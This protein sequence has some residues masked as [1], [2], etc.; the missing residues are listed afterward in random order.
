[1]FAPPT[2][3]YEFEL[4][5]LRTLPLLPTLRMDAKL[6]TLRS[7]QALPT[8]RM[9]A[10]LAID[11]RLQ[12]L[13]RL[14]R[15]AAV[16]RN[17]QVARVVIATAA[18]A[19]V[20]FC[21]GIRTTNSSFDLPYGI[22]KVSRRRAGQKNLTADSAASDSR[23]GTMSRQHV[24]PELLFM[25]ER[26]VEQT[27]AHRASGIPRSN[28][29]R[30][31]LL[32]LSIGAVEDLRHCGPYERSDEAFCEVFQVCLP[33][34]GL[35]VWHVGAD[36]V[37][38]DANQAVF[39]RAGEP[40]RM[41]APIGDGYAELI[42]TADACVLADIA[43]VAETLISEH[44][45]FRR[46]SW[47]VGPALQA[48]RTRFLHWAT[49]APDIDDLQADE[50]V[51]AVLR[52]AFQ[53]DGRRR[54]ACGKRT[55]RLIRRAKEFLQA[56]LA[57]RVQLGDVSRAVAASPAYLTDVFR[58]V[59]GLSLHQYLTQLRLGRALVELPYTNDLTALALETGFSS[60]SHFSAVF[61]RAFG[62]TP[63]RFRQTSRRALTWKTR[64]PLGRTA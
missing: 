43:G 1:V 59:E 60:H 47:L 3:R 39:V 14:D 4:P 13:R 28:G 23:L 2:L 10:K 57:E 12:A 9:L 5:T 25:E 56:H 22:V 48:V 50:A 36:D 55:T 64:T 61:R 34:D 30:S 26:V 19:G 27:T 32:N 52:A 41:S 21:F 31:R 33:Y 54:D 45:L 51:I 44:P 29:Y 58:R 62:V 7:E 24:P 17:R 38:G 63:S 49:T 16:C 11:Q 40:Y 15:A 42:I 46:R 6:P 37:I 35:F 53:D 8:L 20:Q 18:T